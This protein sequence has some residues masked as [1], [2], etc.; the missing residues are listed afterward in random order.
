MTCADCRLARNRLVRGRVAQ[1]T[2][3]L[4]TACVQRDGPN[5]AQVWSGECRFCATDTIWPMAT[6]DTL[7]LVSMKLV[8][9]CRV[10]DY[11]S[12][13]PNRTMT[14][15]RFPRSMA[16]FQMVGRIQMAS[17]ASVNRFPMMMGY[18]KSPWVEHL[19]GTNTH[20]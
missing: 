20:G 14:M 5:C 16:S 1:I 7:S 4:M 2:D 8:K 11:M 17:N 10:D 15:T 6:K 9:G 19:D 18:W 3:R 12:R 13:V